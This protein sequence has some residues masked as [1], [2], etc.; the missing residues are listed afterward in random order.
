VTHRSRDEDD[1]FDR[2]AADGKFK[3]RYSG[4]QH[5]RNLKANTPNLFVFEGL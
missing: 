1:V 4:S 5:P 2:I 3:R